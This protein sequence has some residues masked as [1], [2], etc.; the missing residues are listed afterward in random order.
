MKIKGSEG[1]RCS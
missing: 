1:I